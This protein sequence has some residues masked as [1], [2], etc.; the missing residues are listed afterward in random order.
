[1]QLNRRHFLGSAAAGAAI[2]ATP[3]WSAAASFTPEQFGAR[4]DGV[5]ND[6]EAFTRMAAAVSARGGGEIVLRKA[7]YIVGRQMKGMAARTGYAFEPAPIL[8]FVGLRG[9]LLIRGNGARLKCADGLRYGTFHPVSG[10]KTRNPMPYTQGGELATPYRWMIRAENCSGPVEISDLE[11]DGNLKRLQIGGQYGDTGWQIP[12]GGIFLHNNS[13]SEKIAR[14]YS[15][16]HAQD[17]IQI[18]G[19]DRSRGSTAAS[20]LEDVRCE[21]NARQGV[22]LVGGRG[23]SF[24]RCKFNHTG[25]AGLAS[26]PGAGVDIEAEQ[27]KKVRDISFSNCEFSNNTGAGLVADS[28]DSEGASFTGCTF[29]GT[30][31]WSAW[32]NKLRFRFAGCTFVGAMVHAIGDPRP[33]RATQF[34]DCTFRDDPALSPTGEIYGGENTSRPIADLP[35]NENVLFHRCKFLLTHRSVLPW[36]VNV[37]YSDCTLSQRAPAESYPRGTYIGRNTITGRGN[38]YGSNIVGELIHNG[39]RI[40]RGR[41]S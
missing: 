36:S 22:S 28:G 17:G 24:S 18:D 23:Y 19:V 9:A 38:I 15:H 30:T 35:G 41:I 12:A 8:D 25:K 4:G 16:H 26:A 3:A 31:N 2:A 21:Y 6:T 10:A 5:T 37:I 33:E 20:I 29:V 27:G 14:V 39:T 34:H 1:M 40:P 11:L 7:T 13:G 32:P